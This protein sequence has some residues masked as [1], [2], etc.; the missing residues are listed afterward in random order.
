MIDRAAALSPHFSVAEGVFSSTAERL[1]I[2]NIP[3]ADILADMEV[4]AAGMEQV[5]ALL[6]L[7]IHVDSWYRCPKLNAA[8][9]GAKYSAHMDGWAV[10]FTC[11]PLSTEAIVQA[12][13]VSNIQFDQCIQEGSWVH[14]S[15]APELRRHVLTA[16]F[17][18]GGTTYTK[19]A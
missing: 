4:A 2:A 3:P 8:V 16:H 12:I 6:G 18:P 7:P 17:G 13:A 11:K 19:G 10:D 14:I 1:A 15:F 9:G 5:R